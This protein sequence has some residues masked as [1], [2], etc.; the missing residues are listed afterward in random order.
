MKYK[1]LIIIVIVLILFI[2]KPTNISKS[3]NGINFDFNNEEME[4]PVT[5][6]ING[7]ITRD[8]MLRPKTFKG[9]ISVDSNI[10]EFT[11]PVSFMPIPYGKSKKYYELILDFEN[12]SDWKL[13]HD[14]LY[15]RFGQRALWIIYTDRNFSVISIVPMPP[16]KDGGWTSSSEIIAAP[17]DNREDAVNITNKLRIE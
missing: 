14:S 12:V 15:N 8:L 6:G 1:M 4:E 11:E 5:I 2:F 16:D 10:F 9:T 17:C 7:T 3:Y 13:N